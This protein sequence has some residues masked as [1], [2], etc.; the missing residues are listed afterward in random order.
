[1]RFSCAIAIVAILPLLATGWPEHRAE[2]AWVAGILLVVA[3][4]VWAFEHTR[5]G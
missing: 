4:A 1:V 5:R 3:A 2:S